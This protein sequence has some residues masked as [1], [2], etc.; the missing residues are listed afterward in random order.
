MAQ[1]VQPTL[2]N[3]QSFETQLSNFPKDFGIL[4]IGG[5]PT[6]GGFGGIIN[7]IQI[8]GVINSGTSAAGSA[9]GAA[10]TASTIPSLISSFFGGGACGNQVTRFV[11]LIIGVIAVA[12]AIYLY[13]GPGSELISIPINAAKNTVKSVG[14]AA[15][16]S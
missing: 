8:G 10:A 5:D 1:L 12:G 7:P 13:K 6:G 11:L 4:P 3:L 9:I 16:E 2:G 15:M 14:R